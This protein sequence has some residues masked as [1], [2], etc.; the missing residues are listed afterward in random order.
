MRR[1]FTVVQG[2]ISMILPFNTIESINCNDSCKIQYCYEFMSNRA[3][4]RHA[5]IKS[6]KSCSIVSAFNLL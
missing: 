3:S 1:E 2:F 6:L 4:E 5:T